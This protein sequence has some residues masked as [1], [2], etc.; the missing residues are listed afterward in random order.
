[1][2]RHNNKL[3]NQLAC[4]K[5]KALFQTGV[6]TVPCK[7]CPQVYIGETGRKLKTRITVHKMDIHT[8]KAENGIANHVM[9]FGHK[10]DF[11]NASISYFIAVIWL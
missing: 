1:M 5:R 3:S 10:F 11:E 7:S 6:Y 4:N 2:F 9:K 8:M